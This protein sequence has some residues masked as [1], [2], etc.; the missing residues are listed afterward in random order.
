[1][2]FTGLVNAGWGDR[3]RTPLHRGAFA[4][5]PIDA[6]PR[7]TGR[8]DR[9]AD[10]ALEP[11]HFFLPDFLA[12]AIQAFGGA[13]L[14]LATVSD[15]DELLFFA[16]VVASNRRA[17]GVP[18]LR[19]WTH[20]FA[21]LGSPLIH[22]DAAPEVADE[23]MIY[24]RRSGRRSLILPDMPLMGPVARTFRDGAKGQEFQTEAGCQSRPILQMSPIQPAFERLISAKH[25]RDLD[26]QLRRLC[27]R[28]PVSVLTARN[29][30]DVEAAF[31]NF[32][33]LECSGWKGRS[34]TAIDQDAGVQDFARDAVTRLARRGIAAIDLMRVGERVVAALIRFDHAGLSIPWKIAYDESF[35]AFSPGKHLMCD[36]TRRWLLDPSILRADPI[37][38]ESNSLMSGIL[39]DS[40]PY[41]TLFVSAHRRDWGMRLSAG[42]MDLR[43]SGKRRTKALLRKVRR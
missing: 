30:T 42:L 4:L 13:K 36:A 27:E 2:N 19:V 18:R 20:E 21:P 3:V 34:G 14:K 31:A 8:I 6:L 38:E 32:L 40:E 11:N 9:L 17:F 24:L 5:E 28:G 29:A 35:S 43:L 12:P 22:R 16:P 33:A 7:L 15:G 37:C 39:K 10:H 26:R 23:I 41:G 25:R 1:M